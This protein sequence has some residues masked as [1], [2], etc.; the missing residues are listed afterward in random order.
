MENDQNEFNSDYSEDAPTL[1]QV[2][3]MIGDIIVEFGAPW[4]THCQLAQPMVQEVLAGLP[5]LAH[6]KL[7][8]GKGKPLGRAFNVKPWPTLILLRDGKE[9]DRLIRPL[10]VDDIRHLVMQS[11]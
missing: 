11:K 3:E 1:E 4:C 9:I 5:E 7:Y 2:S 8:D 10:C 6:I